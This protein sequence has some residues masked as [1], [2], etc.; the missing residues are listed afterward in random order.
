MKRLIKKI[1]IK[2]ETSQGKLWRRSVRIGF[3]MENVF[4]KTTV[5]SVVFVT[6]REEILAGR[7]FGG[8]VKIRQNP[9]N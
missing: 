2:R 9:P 4:V 7:N 5:Y 8:F 3:N 6:L 1:R